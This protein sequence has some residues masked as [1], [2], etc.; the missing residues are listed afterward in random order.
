MKTEWYTSES[1]M[2]A[3]FLMTYISSTLLLTLVTRDRE[4]KENNNEKS[5]WK[6]SYQI[7]S[8]L[9]WIYVRL[10]I[11]ILNAQKYVSYK[12]WLS[13]RLKY[14]QWLKWL[15]QNWSL[16]K[17]MCSETSIY[18]K[19]HPCFWTPTIN[20]STA[21]TFHRTMIIL[22]NSRCSFQDKISIYLFKDVTWS[23]YTLDLS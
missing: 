10:N 3:N 13:N 14:H 21:Y 6:G 17:F 9:Y 8:T 23:C 2:M 11:V 12:N 5:E 4:K 18:L 15:I 22:W 19:K 1:N 20:V 7:L 16:A